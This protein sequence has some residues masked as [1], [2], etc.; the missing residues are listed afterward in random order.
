MSGRKISG[1]NNKYISDCVLQGHAGLTQIRIF[2]LSV[3]KKDARAA[4]DYFRSI[5]ANLSVNFN[6]MQSA[7]IPMDG[8]DRLK[9]LYSFWHMGEGRQLNMTF[10][11]MVKNGRD[12]KDMIAPSNI[13]YYVDE[14]GHPSED[15]IQIGNRFS[16]VLYLPTA[17]D[18][19][20]EIYDVID[21]VESRMDGCLGDH[22]IESSS[23]F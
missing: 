15:T 21:R 22:S 11:E 9:Y 20:G 17:K 1:I 8:S 14:Y 23:S 2:V 5:E 13:G 18:R 3:R 10:E 6:K 12:W 19:G 16:R 7:L 4:R